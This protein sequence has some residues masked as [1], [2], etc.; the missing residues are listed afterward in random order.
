MVVWVSFD[1]LSG[2]IGDDS[3]VL[4]ATFSEFLWDYGDA[5]APY[6][7]LLADVGARHLATGPTL[8]ANRDTEPDGLPT[9]SADGDDTTGT[10]DDED[11]VT[12]P[13]LIASTFGS[14]TAS[15]TVDLQNADASSNR[16]DA[17]IDFNQDGDW[18]D[19]GERVFTNFDLGTTNGTQTLSITVPED[20]GDNIVYGTT[21]A[22]F[23]LSTAGGL[24]PTGLA[25]DGEVEDYPVAVT[26]F[27]PPE[28]LN[29]NA[30]SDS[31]EDFYPQMTTDGAGNWVAVWQSS[32]SLGGTIGTDYDI[33]VSRSTDA[34]GTW[35]APAAL[36]TNAGSDSGADNRP[37][38]TTD[39]GGN[40]V[41]VWP[42]GDSLGGTIGTDPD[43]LVSRST[44]AGGTW[45]D[46]AALNTN[47]GSDS[48][49]DFGPEV[50]TDGAGNWVAVWHSY[51]SLGG[52]IGIDA[53]ILVSRSA[54]AGVTWTAP[55]AL[56][57]NA[58]TDSGDDL[59]PRI[60]TDGTGNWA[61]VWFSED[62][63]GGTI[64]T[65]RDILVSRSAD[66]GSTW[67]APAALNTNAG[68]DTGDDRHVQL[69]TD[70]AGNWVAVW[71]STDDLG[72]TIGTDDDILVS[73]SADAAGHGPSQRP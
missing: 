15:L 68:S 50:A 31:G 51:D 66:A 49:P 26:W 16:L 9:A 67:T 20:T 13:V 44:D 8:G 38:V 3:D 34:G 6:P 33:L 22:R 73:R 11:G 45:T 69:T 53:D 18:N 54:D 19:S 65:D 41:A 1:N 71:W 59:V 14:T 42:S 70:G 72:G 60:V 27:G 48:R 39:G 47:A 46:P 61:A 4:F 58:G 30:G 29:T 24:L 25:G 32:D 43:I 5:P 21:Y 52:P 62:N 36:N 56:N 57:T 37:Q 63:L 7:T 10:P 64:G 28:A 23:R 17:W 55:V 12:V 40:W 35:T 2:T